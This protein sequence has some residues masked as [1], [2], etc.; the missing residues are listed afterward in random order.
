[1][2][3]RAWVLVV[4]GLAGC[5]LTEPSDCPAPSPLAASPSHSKLVSEGL[6]I[7]VANRRLSVWLTRPDA[8][9]TENVPPILERHDGRNCSIRLP[10]EPSRGFT[11]TP[12]PG[13]PKSLTAAWCDEKKG[14]CYEAIVQLT[15]QP[16]AD[17]P[18]CA[19]WKTD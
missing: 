4:L 15:S 13:C 12:L 11:L 16:S 17:A 3:T 18:F 2:T 19:A 9:F 14:F 5:S 8:T 7:D 10:A 6:A 1:M